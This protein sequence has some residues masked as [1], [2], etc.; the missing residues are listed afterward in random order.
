MPRGQGGGGREKETDPVSLYI[1]R[2][3]NQVDF[4]IF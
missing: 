1:L 3:A 4:L 2:C